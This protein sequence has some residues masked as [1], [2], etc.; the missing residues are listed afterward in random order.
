MRY[1]LDRRK[2]VRVIDACDIGVF[3]GKPRDAVELLVLDHHDPTGAKCHILRTEVISIKTPKDATPQQLAAFD[4]H[5]ERSVWD[6]KKAL[7]IKQLI[8]PIHGNTR[9]RHVHLIHGNSNGQRSLDWGPEFLSKLNDFQ[10]TSALAPGKGRGQRRGIEVYPK[11]RTLS[12]RDLAA[13]LVDEH[14]QL[15]P[16][17]WDGLVQKGE[18]TDFRTRQDGSLIS[19]CFA[20]K[21]IRFATLAA[22]LPLTSPA[23]PKAPAPDAKAQQALHALQRDLELARRRSHRPSRQSPKPKPKRPPL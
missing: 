11:A 20:G 17:R 15:Q 7:G 16:S 9:T 6:L 19:F 4:D 10:W 3:S 2:V 8:A 23:K 18:L 1:M 13:L 22:F 21:R 14:H 12:V 5:L